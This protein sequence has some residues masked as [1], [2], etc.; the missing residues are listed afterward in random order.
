MT[1]LSLESTATVINRWK[2]T[3]SASHSL[4]TSPIGEA[5]FTDSEII[6]VS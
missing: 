5:T 2:P 3:L 6:Y 4:G 1:K